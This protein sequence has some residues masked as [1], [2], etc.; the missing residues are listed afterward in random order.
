MVILLSAGSALWQ[1]GPAPDLTQ[2]RIIAHRGSAGHAPEN[3]LEAFALAIQ[4]G[5]DILELDIRATA[6][7]EFVVIHDEQ[8]DRT[9]NG[10]GLVRE[11]TLAEIRELDAGYTFSPDGMSFP[12][13]GQGVVIPTLR[14]FLQTF[15]CI[16]L[17]L[18]VKDLEPAGAQ[19]LFKLLEDKGALERSAIGSFDDGIMRDIHAVNSQISLVAANQQIAA[20]FAFSRVG[21]ANWLRPDY[22]ILSIPP[23]KGVFRLA[24]PVLIKRARQLGLQV[25]VWTINDEESINYYLDLGVHGI[26][27]AF[28]D[29]V[30]KELDKR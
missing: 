13:R 28:P 22:A 3:T 30:R 5:A 6:G 8:V 24:N 1:P 20:F 14:E 21:M 27:T 10:T 23:T 9:T 29:L 19:A 16:P 15:P 2:V 11:L 18:D 4:Q 12:F 7:G 26:I 25:W 17:L